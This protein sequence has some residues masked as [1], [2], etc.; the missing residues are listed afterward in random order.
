MKRLSFKHP[1]SNQLFLPL[2][3][4]VILIGLTGVF[5][6]FLKPQ[7][8]SL[9]K[10][11]NISTSVPKLP[12]LS[13]WSF[14]IESQ[15]SPNAFQ[16]L[17][18]ELP[19][20]ETSPLKPLPEAEVLEIASKLGFETA[21]KITKDVIRGEVYLWIENGKY[22][23]IYP[24]SNLIDFSF[25]NS[26]IMEGLKLNEDLLINKARDFLIQRSLFTDAELSFSFISYH[27]K[28]PHN[29]QG[30]RSVNPENAN[31]YMINFS[32]QK[33]DYKLLSTTRSSPISV[34]IFPNGTVSGIIITKLNN[35]SFSSNKY[36]VLDYATFQSRL[37][38]AVLVTLDS[39]L[40]LPQ[41]LTSGSISKI[42][43]NQIEIAYLM[44]A[45]TDT[46]IQPVFLLSGEA[47]MLQNN[48]TVNVS[49]YLPAIKS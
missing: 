46:I 22:L 45:E 40:I 30:I 23:S 17:P 44:A 21:P 19:L 43:V 27:Q 28:D 38:N 25:D 2:F 13:K 20:L 33:L 37:Q 4:L 48:Q 10:T 18:K 35:F 34:W 7:K 5:W 47:I 12:N 11:P 8:P 6:V 14:P 15:V 41:D 16:A 24:E 39:G 42:V 3:I 1:F 29:P 31:F 36:P 9:P 26:R 49:L 32:P